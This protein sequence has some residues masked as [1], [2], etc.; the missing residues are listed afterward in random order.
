MVK[1]PF[2]A[3][4]TAAG[5]AGAAFGPTVRAG[6]AHHDPQRGWPAVRHHRR[7]AGSRGAVVLVEARLPE[8]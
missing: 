2:P 5:A 7:N 3:G 8:P 6:A 4:A 1:Y